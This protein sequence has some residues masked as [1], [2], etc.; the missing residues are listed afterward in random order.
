M[1]RIAIAAV[2]QETDTFNPDPTT[3]D[4][5][6]SWGLYESVEMLEALE[7][8]GTVG[9]FLKVLKANDPAFVPVPVVAGAAPPG[10]RL[11]EQTLRY[12]KDKLKS[13]LTGGLPLDG[14]LLSLHGACAAQ[15]V[16]DVDG[17][18]LSLTRSVVGKDVP[19]VAVLD[20][21]A[22]ITAKMIDNADVLV[23]HRTQP[24]DQVDTG[25]LAAELLLNLIQR[26]SKPAM[27]WHKIPMV[28]HQ[29][30]FLTSTGPMKTWFDQAREMER[31]AGVLSVSTFP[32]QPWLDVEE[33]GWSTVVVTDGD[34]SLAEALSAE[35]ATM[36]WEMRHAFM[37]LDSV[38]IEEAVRRAGAAERGMIVLCDTGDSVLGGS[39]GDS[40]VLLAELIKQGVNGPVLVPLVDPAAVAAAY[41]AGKGARIRLNLG[42]YAD[43]FFSAP[44]EIEARVTGTCNGHVDLDWL[45]LSSCEMGRTA[46][47]ELDALRV[48][49]S[50]RRGVGGTHP[51]VY[52]AC[53]LE[54]AAA[55]AIVV[56][57][58][59]NW[60][61]FGKWIS[62]VIR[63]DTPGF[64]QSHLDQLQWNRVPRPMFGLDPQFNWSTAL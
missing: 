9:A 23:G 48:L 22:N 35:L 64:T 19:V 33:A 1:P 11:D 21:H 13:G 4:D 16:D 8:V 12:F 2:S 52:R 37:V 57:T 10:G 34:R 45:G 62:K 24:H 39:T 17:E 20:H 14:V 63:V 49:V 28:T 61:A 59:S 40:T 60:H 32:M 51:A 55:R 5:F 56:K 15:E 7:N 54:P 47:L 26:K 3:I 41:S 31:M 42:G 50:E 6:R 25:W 46:L 53:G 58:G 38:P 27:V 30:Q 18:L 43:R 44:L 36:V 29:E